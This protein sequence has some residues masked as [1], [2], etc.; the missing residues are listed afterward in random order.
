MT[1]PT[2]DDQA[3]RQLIAR[4]FGEQLTG[5]TPAALPSTTAPDVEEPAQGIFSFAEAMERADPA[6]DEIDLFVPPEPEPLHLAGMRIQTQLGIA[7]LVQAVVVGVLQL[8]G[9]WMPGWVGALSGLAAAGGL[10]TLLLGIPRHRD[11]DD[12]GVRL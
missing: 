8:F 6:P 3:F 9:F 10:L 11:D 2:D 7:L 4:E 12:D 5:Q 1:K